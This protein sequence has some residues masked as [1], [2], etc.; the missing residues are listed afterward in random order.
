MR[1]M[2]FQSYSVNLKYGVVLCFV[3]VASC[4]SKGELREESAAPRLE[5]LV[6]VQPA[7]VSRSSKAEKEKALLEL[8]LPQTELVPKKPR[9]KGPRF[10]LSAEDVD[11]KAILFSI[12]REIDQNIMIDPVIS[13]KV[14]LN[15]KEVTLKEM[16][17]HVLLPLNLM[18]EVDEE[19]IRVVPLEMQTRIFRMNYLISKRKTVGNLQAS[20]GAGTYEAPQP[21]GLGSSRII[22]SEETDLWQ[23]IAQ[24]LQKMVAN[25]RLEKTLATSQS[26]N[27][28]P[29]E[30]AWF[31]VNKQSGV[32]VVNAFPE[33]LLKVAEFLE[34]VEGSVQRQVLIRARVLKVALKDDYPAGIDWSRLTP[35]Q[36]SRSQNGVS[37]SGKGMGAR[38]YL[39]GSQEE[40]VDEMLEALAL[41]GDVSVL[42][43][44]QISAL[45]NQRA[46]IR[47]GTQDTVFVPNPI[48]SGVEG[49]AAYIP[50]PMTL[51]VVLDVV[52]QININGNV[53]MSVHVNVTKKAGERVSP[54]GVSRVPV[55]DIRE[56]N[57]VVMARNGQTV[58]IGGLT[59]RRKGPKDGPASALER[60][61]IFGE[62]FQEN[63]TTY[64][65]SELLILLT[66]EIMVGSAID[67]RL[68]IEEK[69]L[70]RTGL[71]RHTHN[72]KTSLEGK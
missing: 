23:E 35:L 30:K 48:R 54:D 72:M 69:R 42:A 5:N 43:S 67:D 55:V 57:N 62:M 16:L 40:R 15:L 47:V 13:Q 46:V 53:I 49:E 7:S 25:E 65:K 14:T 3:F 33:V 52:P 59:G 11:V 20:L 32:L 21:G 63:R 1:F 27:G 68:R 28:P 9:D 34:E 31:S 56:S 41:Q 17:D 71:P 10:S 61:P 58:V 60:V 26:V 8:T 45:N 6:E 44:P 50:Q 51:G 37:A 29:V 36:S 2:G 12:S 18:Y 24:G 70:K 38:G 4:V 66:P 39:Y 19:F 22:S 64:E